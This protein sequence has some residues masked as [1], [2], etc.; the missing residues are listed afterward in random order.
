MRS[1]IYRMRLGRYGMLNI[2]F[3]YSNRTISGVTKHLWTFI[4]L[5]TS[6]SICEHKSLK[7]I[8]KGRYIEIISLSGIQLDAH[9]DYIGGEVRLG[10]LHD[11][12][13]TL[14]LNGFSFSGSFKAALNNL[15]LSKDTVKINGYQGPK[16]L[17]IKDVEVM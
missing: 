1:D 16:Y 3:E 2:S 8:T 11:K 14:P 6:F 17:R 13:K 5:N 10:V 15:V 12:G 9:A 7:S 4:F